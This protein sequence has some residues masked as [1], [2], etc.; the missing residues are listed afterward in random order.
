MNRRLPGLGLPGHATHA[1]PAPHPVTPA[2]PEPAPQPPAAPEPGIGPAGGRPARRAG[3]RGLRSG[4]VLA[5][6]RSAR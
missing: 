3:L 4:R 1:S 2:P 5:A 6:H